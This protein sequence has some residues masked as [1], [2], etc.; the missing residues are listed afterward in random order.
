MLLIFT[1]MIIAMAKQLKLKQ[2]IY[3]SVMSK[4]YK[5]SEIKLVLEEETYENDF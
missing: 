4:G 1:I 5:T 2:K 3:A